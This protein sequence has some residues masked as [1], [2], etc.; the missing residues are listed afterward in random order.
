VKDSI[1]KLIGAIQ[2]VYR[3]VMHSKGLSVSMIS[4]IESEV[5]DIMNGTYTKYKGGNSD[6][7][8]GKSR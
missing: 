7:D 5:T 2:T 6:A 1:R 8:R 3:C 4:L